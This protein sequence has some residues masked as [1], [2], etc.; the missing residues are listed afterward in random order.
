MVCGQRCR[1][2]RIN[3]TLHTNARQLLAVAVYPCMHSREQNTVPA[4]EHV[5]IEREARSPRIDTLSS[6]SEMMKSPHRELLANA[7]PLAIESLTGSLVKASPLKFRGT[8]TL[9]KQ[10]RGPHSEPF[11][12]CETR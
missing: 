12:W 1:F 7:A 9:A 2:N 10:A 4:S 11:E 8:D 3:S 6:L 5:P